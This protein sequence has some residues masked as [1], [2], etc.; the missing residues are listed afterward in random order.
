MNADTATTR[1]RSLLQGLGFKDSVI[2]SP[3]SVLSSGNLTRVYLA[4]IL[5]QRCD[6]LLLDEPTNFL[7]LSALLWLQD[8]L[9]QHP[10]TLVLVT[11]D[12]AFADA[13]AEEVIILRDQTLERFAGTLSAYHI[14][15]AEKIIHLTKMADAQE[16]QKAHMQASIAS[17]HAA[18]KRSGD[19]KKLSQAASRKKKLEDRMG[20]ETSA[21]GTRFKLVSASLFRVPK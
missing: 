21:K 7:D 19:T 3:V 1:A 13:I 15:R 20:I 16:R 2:E 8:N 5:F 11:H 4:S 18:A 10:A 9:E 17:A 6:L 12:R 14:M